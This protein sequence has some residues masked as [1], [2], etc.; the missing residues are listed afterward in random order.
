MASTGYPGMTGCW[1]DLISS[2]IISWMY[3]PAFSAGYLGN[4]LAIFDQLKGSVMKN[5]VMKQRLAKQRSKRRSKGAR[6]FLIATAFSAGLALP[7]LAQTMQA[8]P[9]DSAPVVAATPLFDM[10]F[11]GDWSPTHWRSSEAVGQAVYNRANERIGEV[12]ELLIDADG[13]VFATVVAVGGFLGMGERNV[14][15]SYRAFQMTRDT[16]GKPRLVVNID[17]AALEKAPAYK[18]TPA[19]KRS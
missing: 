19:P 1:Q 13:R 3:A 10:F 17:K 15:V 2:Q 8:P 4:D 7:A 14:A 12:E 6:L 5:H 11:T 9:T 18:P 16:N